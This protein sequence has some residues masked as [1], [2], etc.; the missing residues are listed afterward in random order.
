MRHRTVRFRSSSQRSPD[1]LLGRLFLGRS[2]PRLLNAAAPGGLEPAPEVDSGR[3]SPIFGTALQVFTYIR[4]TPQYKIL[5]RFLSLLVK[6]K[7]WPLKGSCCR[8]VCTW[9]Y[10]RLKPARIS[11]GL[12]A[13]VVSH[14]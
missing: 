14:K 12:K 3:P 10:K 8:V 1:V 9:V 7:R 6:T 11:T 5:I 4:D 13:S 2:P